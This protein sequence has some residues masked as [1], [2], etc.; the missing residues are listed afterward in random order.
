MSCKVYYLH[1]TSF[2]LMCRFSASARL[3]SSTLVIISQ[4]TVFKYQQSIHR[5][6]L[7]DSQ[8]P[9]PILDCDITSEHVWHKISF[10]S[11]LV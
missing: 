1:C 5:C 9:E 2:V 10:N 11:G 8:N 4:D 7:A 6:L 3:H